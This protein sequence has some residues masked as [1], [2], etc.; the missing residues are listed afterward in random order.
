MFW[1]MYFY[2]IGFSVMF[3]CTGEGIVFGIPLILLAEALRKKMV[4]D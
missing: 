3:C 4:V 2:I 1:L